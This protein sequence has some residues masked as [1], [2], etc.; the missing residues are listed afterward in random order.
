MLSFNKTKNTFIILLLLLFFISSNLYAEEIIETN[1]DNELEIEV[2]V[3][4]E[5]N[6]IEIVDGYEFAVEN[7]YLKLYVNHDTAEVAVQ[8]KSTGEIW[9]T[10]P[11]DRDEMETQARGSGLDAMSS[12][13]SF[14]FFIQADRQRSMNSYNDSVSRGQFQ[15][16]VNDNGLRVDYQF[17]R[18]WEDEDYIPTIIS[19]EIFENELAVHLSDS[20]ANFLRNQYNLIE[21]VEMDEDYQRLDIHGVDKDALFGD[22]TIAILD[23]NMS[24]RNRRRLIQGILGEIQES[25]DY[26][27]LSNVTT[28]DLEYYFDN[29]TYV[30]KSQIMPWDRERMIDVVQKSGFTPDRI[31]DEHLKY[32]Y[33]IPYPSLRLFEIALEYELDARDL[34]VRVPA[35][36]IVYPHDVFDQVEGRRVTLPLTSLRVLPYFDAANREQDGYIFVPDGS[37][38]LIHL[39]NGKTNLSPY[40]RR[41]YG[42]DFTRTD[43]AE[44][45]P[46]LDEDIYMPVF[47][48]NHGERGFLA[49][50]EEADG[51]AQINALVSGMRDSYNRAFAN[52]D[53]IAQ[54]RERMT[55]VYEV[56]T[57]A[58]NM[59]QERIAS[60][61]IQIRYKLLQ[62]EESDYSSM[63]R[64]YQ[65]Y[66]V[67]KHDLNRIAKENEDIPFFL[68]LI[69]GVDRILPVMGVQTRVVE[70]LTTYNQ[71]NDIVSEF[72]EKGLENLVLKYSGWSRGGYKHYYPAAARLERK[73]GSSSDFENLR[74]M[75]FE[76]NMAFYPD[77]S[78]LNVYETRLFDG[79]SP[80]RDNARLLNRRQAFIYDEFNISTFRAEEDKTKDILSPRALDSLVSSFLDSY[81]RYDI[82]ALSLRYIG[83]H[84]HADYRI[85]RDR[86]V[87]REESKNLVIEQLASINNDGAMSLL[88]NGGNAYTLPFADYVLNMP[89]YSDAHLLL[90]EAIPFYQMVL[91]G[92]F[93]YSG[94]PINLADRLN[95]YPLK[96]LEIG[97]LPYYKLSHQESNI[98]KQSDYENLY[99]IHYLDY[100]D[101]AVAYY[102]E[103]NEVLREVQGMRIFSHER[104]MD[105]VYK[106]SYENGISILVNYNQED[107]DYNGIII[108][109]VSYEV[110]RGEM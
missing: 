82:D 2:E 20:D 57:L 97:A 35:D 3:E 86:L 85:G 30:Q 67:E 36:S 96:L 108:P 66:L 59:Y 80:R 6:I 31:Q 44:Y 32:N 58:I 63:A 104:L 72:K 17:G 49:I 61:D 68:E 12:Q 18:E 62:D 65:E 52:F 70:P 73:L 46:Y 53:L 109:A 55:G 40:Q 76:N 16:D 26:A 56:Q 22:Y 87:D 11:P 74:D 69:G 43:V 100:I 1:L 48:I 27:R 38:A 50:I 98:L 83:D 91:H 105:R 78:F 24:D 42:R 4:V 77:I 28:E 106:T 71:A 29:P 15:I 33:P 64:T 88:I 75:L 10:N 9:Y 99:S 7:E 81:S 41:V 92:Y 37:G 94:N 5:D 93:Q 79:Y 84:L 23:E 60:T 34:L 101:E 110:I 47:G 45:A 8:D 51:L 103:V 95:T 14:D 54:T 90:D 89:V 102:H 25:M 13:L 39:N 107:V 19:Q 21:L